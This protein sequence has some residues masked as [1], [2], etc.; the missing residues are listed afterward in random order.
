MCH[1]VLQFPVYELLKQLD[2]R[3]FNFVHSEKLVIQCTTTNHSI[4]DIS[5]SIALYN[6]AFI[7]SLNI[8]F[9]TIYEQIP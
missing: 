1:V 3:L 7:K 2:R 8:L 6:A 9:S 4:D 5:G